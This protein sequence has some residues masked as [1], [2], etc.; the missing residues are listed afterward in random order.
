MG[1][2]VDLT[3]PRGC[4]ESP[5]PPS[6]K[7]CRP[8]IPQGV[9]RESSTTQWE[10]VSTL[11][12]P[13]GAKRV[14]HHPVGRRVDLTSPRGCQE[15]PAPPSG[16]A[17]RPYIPQGAPGESSTTQWE[18]VSTLHPPGGARRVQH[19]PVGRRVDLTSPRGRQE[20]PAPPSG[21]ACRPCVPPGVTRRVQDHSAAC[22]AP[23]ASR[24]GLTSFDQYQRR[25]LG[26][27]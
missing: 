18:G 26:L 22:A 17:C 4:Q 10:G 5:A 1:R 19:H 15:S 21:K 25:R 13:G 11:H 24:T 7:A 8:Y 3:S 20:S 14:Q 23:L 6:G 9:P 16:K 12:P 2:R 27:L